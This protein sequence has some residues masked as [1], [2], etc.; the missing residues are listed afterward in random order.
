[1]LPL[2]NFLS[3]SRQAALGPGQASALSHVIDRY[4]I[5]ISDLCRS[6]GGQSLLFLECPSRA[7]MAP[8][9][10]G[11]AL[12]VL[13]ADALTDGLTVDEALDHPLWL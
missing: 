8:G 9:P 7:G 6:A 2:S 4:E 12:E 10:C 11:E 13:E 5:G 1:M 3:Y